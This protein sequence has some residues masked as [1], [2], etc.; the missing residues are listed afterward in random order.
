M[1][2]FQDVEKKI[3]DLISDEEFEILELEEMKY[4]RLARKQRYELLEL[5][6]KIKRYFELKEQ[7]SIFGNYTSDEKTELNELEKQLKL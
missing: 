7:L 4:I 5:K 3:K 1:T 2:T 6:Q